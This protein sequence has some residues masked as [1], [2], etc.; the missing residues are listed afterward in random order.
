[1]LLSLVLAV[2][3]RA[4]DITTLY[5]TTYREVRLVRVEPDGVTWTHATGLCKVPFADLPEA[6]RRTYHYD[7]KPAA[8]NLSLA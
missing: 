4:D 6:V 8:G 1:M 7:A 5:G 3:A 2:P